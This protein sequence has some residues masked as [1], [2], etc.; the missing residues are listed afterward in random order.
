[1]SDHDAP[2]NEAED[3]QADAT[4]A[5][6]AADAAGFTAAWDA[7][8]D[9]LN[10]GTGADNPFAGLE[11]VMADPDIAAAVDADYRASI[12]FDGTASDPIAGH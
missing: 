8:M 1:M 11:H 4:A 7:D 12:G 10:R 6:S 2:T 5:Q 3:H 9:A